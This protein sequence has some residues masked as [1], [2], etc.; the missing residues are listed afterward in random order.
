MYDRN[1][2][3][4]TGRGDESGYS[5]K[6][7]DYCQQ[8]SSRRRQQQHRKASFED[9]SN[10]ISFQLNV[11]QGML[12]MLAPVRV[13]FKF[14]NHIARIVVIFSFLQDSQKHVIPG[15]LGEFIV[16]LQSCSV[17]SVN[18]FHGNSNLGY[19]CI[20]GKSAEVYHCGKK[21]FL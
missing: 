16:K 10:A 8:Q 5:D 19:L 15:Q 21:V 2:R 3:R 17:F 13:S 9:R 12:T 7:H 20:Q 11:G 1:S 14:R 6:R 18:G 4:L